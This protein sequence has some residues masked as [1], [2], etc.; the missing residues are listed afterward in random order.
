MA[1]HI[2]RLEEPILLKCAYNPRHDNAIPI[3]IPMAF[4]TE[5]EKYG[6]IKDLEWPKQSWE[7]I[8][9]LVASNFLILN[10]IKKIHNQNNMILPLKLTNKPMEQNRQPRNNPLIYVQLISGNGAK[11]THWR[12]DIFNKWCW[13]NW[14]P[15]C[16]RKKLAPYLSPQ[17]QLS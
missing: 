1:F 9:N 3:K 10:Y 5:I 13:G 7:R 11:N 15:I 4:F 2:Q 8:K 14:I 17:S 16:Q 12:K 6:N